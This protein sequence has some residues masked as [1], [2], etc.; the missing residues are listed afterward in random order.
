[1]PG[2][3]LGTLHRLFNPGNKS[4]TKVISLFPQA[5]ESQMQL[6]IPRRWDGFR[7]SKTPVGWFRL[8]SIPLWGFPVPLPWAQDAR[9]PEYSQW[10][11]VDSVDA[12]VWTY[13]AQSLQHEVG[14]L[15]IYQ[16][17]LTKSSSRVRRWWWEMG[18][19]QEDAS[20]RLSWYLLGALLLSRRR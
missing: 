14:L 3:F 18:E 13:Y 12:Q 9:R 2:I 4:V 8:P 10:L 1:M 17:T 5:T 6:S 7:S 19:S 20:T 16:S 15:R 11:A